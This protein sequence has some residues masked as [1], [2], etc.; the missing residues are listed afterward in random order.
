MHYSHFGY[1]A[2]EMK[3][4]RQ[5]HICTPIFIPASFTVIKIW[6]QPER[7]SMGERIKQMW[8]IYTMKYYSGLKRRFYHFQKHGLT[9]RTFI[10]NKISQL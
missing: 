1:A 5:G 7:S 4:V 8:S 6:N 2:K 3:S 9:W 10:L